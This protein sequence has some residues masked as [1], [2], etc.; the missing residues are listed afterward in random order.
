MIHWA[1]G[2][3]RNTK[4]KY[5]L[6]G[7]I[8]LYGYKTVFSCYILLTNGEEFRL[9]HFQSWH[10]TTHKWKLENFAKSFFLFHC[11]LSMCFPIFFKDL[12][13][14]FRGRGHMHA[15]KREHEMREKQ[16]E[17]TRLPA[18]Q[19][20]KMQGWLPAPQHHDPSQNEESDAQ[21]TEPPR[22]P[23]VFLF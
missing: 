14:Y 15:C 8:L 3:V 23:C 22:H 18:E 17:R 5:G 20:A 12:F 6:H 10:S 16:R 11:F 7:L 13:I 19:G 2:S 4:T 21:L 9:V 1:T